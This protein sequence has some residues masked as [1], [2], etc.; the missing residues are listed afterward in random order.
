VGATLVGSRPTIHAPAGGAL[1]EP[2]AKAWLT[3]ANPLAKTAAVLHAPSFDFRC[4]GSGLERWRVRRFEL[5]EELSGRS[6]AA[7]E[8]DHESAQAD[9][10]SLLSGSAVLELGRGAGPT[11][12]FCGIVRAVDEPHGLAWGERRR[13]QIKVEPAFFCLDEEVLTRPFVGMT[14]P[15]ILRE[16]LAEALGRFDGRQVELRLQRSADDAGDDGFALRELIVQYGEST[17]DFCR[18]LMA[19]E[20]M[21]YFFDHSGDVEKLVIVD[22]RQFEPAGSPV[23]V[24]PA[25]GLMAPEESIARLSRARKR[26]AELPPPERRSPG[27]FHRVALPAV[28]RRWQQ[29]TAGDETARGE[30]DVMGLAPGHLLVVGGDLEVPLAPW[31]CGEFLVTEVLA[32]GAAPEAF[33]AGQTAE[34]A[35][36]QN[37]FTLVP[38][39]L[40][41]RP[42]ALPRPTALEDWALVLSAF[43][44]DPIDT[45]GHGRVRVQFLYDRR[46]EAGVERRSS[47]IPVA[48]GWAGSGFGLQIIPRAGM[49]ARI[50]YVLGDPDRPIVAECFPTGAN[51]LPAALPEE[52][53]R[54]T[55]R[56]R[57]LRDGG[58]DTTH[59]NEIALDD[60]ADD[61]ELFLHAGRNLRRKVLRDDRT[62][63]EHDEAHLVGH[64][65]SLKVIAQRTKLVEAGESETV[66]ENRHTTIEGD[67]EQL[68][69]VGQSGGHDTD[70]VDGESTLAVKLTRTTT[71][72]GLAR[73]TFGDSR[74]QELKGDHRTHVSRVRA[75]VADEEWRAA[76]MKTAV[77]LAGG[78]AQI[79]A[80]GELEATTPNGQ[81][82]LDPTGSGS[83][84]FKELRIVCGASQLTMSGRSIAF[85]SPLVLARGPQGSIKLDAQGS[86]TTAKEI[87]ASA[88]MLNELK[89]SLV[90]ISDTPGAGDPLV[91]Q[92]HAVE[93]MAMK[94]TQLRL[95]APDEPKLN[96][97]V[98]LLGSDGKPAANVAYK[99]ML[100]TGEL[101]QGKTN[102]AGVL[103]QKLPGAAR[104]A[105]LAY[106]PAPG[107]GP[108]TRTLALVDDGAE[109]APVEQLRQLG[110]G[111]ATSPDEEVVREFQG[112]SRLPETG[113]LDAE[114]RRALA[115][116]SA[117]RAPGSGA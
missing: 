108:I 100:P 82:L 13:C 49:L 98:S 88:V 65:Q 78:H 5:H 74:T 54:L 96:L 32:T 79:L 39:R 50:E 31:A 40:G 81:L 113:S 38:A 18:R 60:A 51:R 53:T 57:S 99:L 48:Q 69:A 11:R 8:L 37:S 83:A 20:G 71:V 61:E 84:S 116:L 72:A 59:F 103:A 64:D 107:A 24:F 67:D 25:Q 41:F 102:G 46:E 112:A 9:P 80:D 76:Q 106:E 111:G 85:K 73:G 27:E 105:E 77:R 19:E 10:T 43:E 90:V 45:D 75:V 44:R 87:T 36:Y 16:V 34:D 94:A 55:L 110:F 28:E 1:C 7:I 58:R 89:G 3:D 29:V 114:T 56:S 15:Q 4:P 47:W 101:F 93:A 66:L 21:T 95:D 33:A 97:E 109:N 42:A 62:E 35:D 91:P 22:E 23:R 30:S 52:K 12:R 6:S 70:T 2:T 14:V 26:S 92:K 63:V 104:T 115:S 17:H 86:T 117:G 68:I